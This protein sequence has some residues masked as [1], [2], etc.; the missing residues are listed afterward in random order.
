MEQKRKVETICD[1]HREEVTLI[2]FGNKVHL[3]KLEQEQEQEQEQEHCHKEQHDLR[4][5][6]CHKGI[7]FASMI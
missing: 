1:Y 6:L 5:C 2:A 3:K 7:R 4:M